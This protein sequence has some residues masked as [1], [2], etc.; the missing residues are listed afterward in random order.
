M[1]VHSWVAGLMHIYTQACVVADHQ[2]VSSQADLCSW[3]YAPLLP[4]FH[5]APA[6]NCSSSN[7]N[8]ILCMLCMA[9]VHIIM[10]VIPPSR[11]CGVHVPLTSLLH[12]AA[13]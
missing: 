8:S 7:R 2:C 6:T 4:S 11:H 3:L 9:I 1:G 5:Y 13:E 10:P 12:R